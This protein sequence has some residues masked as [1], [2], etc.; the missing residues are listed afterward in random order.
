MFLFITAL[1]FM[2]I[3]KLRFPKKVS[4]VTI[5]N[6]PALTLLLE[7]PAAEEE[8]APG[9]WE[10]SWAEVLGIWDSARVVSTSAGLLFFLNKR[11][12]NNTRKAEH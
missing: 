3:S 4:I 8:S 12:N 10:G 11:I 1:I 6:F 9:S 7:G 5:F 2:F